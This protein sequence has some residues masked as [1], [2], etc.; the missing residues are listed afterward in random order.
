M[1]MSEYPQPDQAAA[2]LADIRQRQEHVIDAVLVPPWYWW[3][4]A[5]G[6][7][8]IGAAADSRRPAVL[9]TVIPAAALIIALLTGAMIF[10]A[11]RHAQVRSSELLRGRG[12]VAIVAFVWLVV[13]LTLGL[14]FALRAGGVHWPAT[15]ATVAGAA[16]L[17]GTGPLLM[18]SL[19]RIMLANRA[20]TALPGSQARGRR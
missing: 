18:R 9:G 15:I 13:G 1:V 19:R 2:A 3:V 16:V 6:M 12:A 10:G 7:V 8:A 5:A 14:G 17:A 11:Y 20:G 4:V